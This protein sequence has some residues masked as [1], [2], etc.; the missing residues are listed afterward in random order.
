MM[1]EIFA[2]GIVVVSFIAVGW[3]IINGLSKLS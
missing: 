2:M 3:I 1:L